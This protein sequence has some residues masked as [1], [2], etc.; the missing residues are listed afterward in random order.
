MTIPHPLPRQ[1]TTGLQIPC[2]FKVAPL[3]HV[4]PPQGPPAP[5]ISGVTH[6]QIFALQRMSSSSSSFVGV[7]FAVSAFCVFG[8]IPVYFKQLG[9]V[10]VIQIALHRFFWTFPE[11]LLILIA[12]GQAKAFF[13]QAFTRSNFILY[14]LSA[15]S[16]AASTMVFVW[17]V[18]AGYILEI[19]LGAFLN[20][21]TMVV[22]GCGFLGERLRRSQ[23]VAVAFAAIGI[24]IFTVSYGRFP[25]IA[26]LLTMGDGAYAYLKKKAPLSSLHSLALESALLFPFCLAGLVVLEVQGQGAFGH[27]N[28]ST[29]LLL[30]G[31]G[32][33]TILPLFLLVSAMQ[34]TPL[35]SIGLFA[36]ISPTIQF[37]VSVFV[38]HEPFSTSK[39][40][41]FVFLWVSIG[42]FALDSIV[43]YKA[44]LRADE[45]DVEKGVV[46]PHNNDVPATG[47][48]KVV[49]A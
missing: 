10:P 13:V 12:T 6:F 39:L 16:L 36:N 34:R 45:A 8:L 1:P 29:N 15:L 19:S 26:I 49:D 17:A 46:T 43:A 27:A 2:K 3:R 37:L 24:S 30:V 7:L 14:G 32:V 48:T 35:Y 47:F 4:P 20:P 18:H 31:T 38:Y 28:L 44:S 41:G 21:L 25:W 9:D 5:F 33:M 42:V 23:V 22:V 40:I 11:T